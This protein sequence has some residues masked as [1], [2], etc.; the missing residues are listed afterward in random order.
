M[1]KYLY[2]LILVGSLTS[3]IVARGQQLTPEALEKTAKEADARGG[4]SLATVLQNVVKEIYE[5]DNYIVYSTS[6]KLIHR[7]GDEVAVALIHIIGPS[8]V[9]D[10]KIERICDLLD[11]AFR[12]PDL[13]EK[14][15]DRNPDVSLLLLESDRL[16]TNNPVLRGKVSAVQSH[17]MSLYKKA[18]E[19]R[20]STHSHPRVP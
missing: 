19:P 7:G 6:D 14:P 17:L 3:S 20:F 4:Q 5:P 11:S 2:S 10:S 16:R 12:F 9:S 8:T 15:G 1:L 13:I 18:D